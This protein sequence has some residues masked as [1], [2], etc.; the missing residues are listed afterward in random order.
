[1]PHSVLSLLRIYVR[2]LL[3]L[4]DLKIDWSEP[5]LVRSLLYLSAIPTWQE[6][7]CPPNP[8]ESVSFVAVRDSLYH[9]FGPDGKPHPRYV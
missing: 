3:R 2:R 8:G 1:M 7:H 5:F 6:S 9:V 4:H